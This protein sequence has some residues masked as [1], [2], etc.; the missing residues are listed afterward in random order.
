MKEYLIKQLVSM[1]LTMLSPDTMKKAVDG[2][3]DIVEDA[4]AKSETTVDDAIV[5]PLCQ[6]VRSAFNIPDND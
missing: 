3:L 4:V 1:L 6:T 5:L 2:V